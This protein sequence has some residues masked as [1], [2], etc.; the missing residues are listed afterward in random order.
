MANG[1]GISHEKQPTNKYQ[2]WFSVHEK[3]LQVFTANTVGYLISLLNKMAGTAQ[4]HRWW[5]VVPSEVMGSNSSTSEYLQRLL[6]I[7]QPMQ[8]LPCGQLQA[9]SECTFLL[10]KFQAG[11]RWGWHLLAGKKR[12]S[13]PFGALSF[14]NYDV[15]LKGQD[16]ATGGD[17]D[18]TGFPWYQ[19]VW[20]VGRCP[21]WALPSRL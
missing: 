16:W 19:C 20:P 12:N 10:G 3:T 7:Q 18:G 21:I 15:G 11:C 13:V 9:T 5:T 1:T 8:T 6:I 2:S 17:G 4:Q 14:F